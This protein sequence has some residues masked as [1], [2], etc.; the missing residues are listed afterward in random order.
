VTI[1][2][3]DVALVIASYNSGAEIEET[4]ETVQA[5]LDKQPYSHEIIVVN[6]GST[7][8]TPATLE[9]FALRCPE[10]RVLVNGRNMGKGYSVTRGMLSTDARFVFFTDADL[11]YPVE[12]IDAFLGPLRDGTHDLVVGSRVHPGSVFHLHPRY[13]RYVYRRHLMSRTFNWVVRASLGIRVMDTQ[14]GFKG[15]TGEAARAIF[16]RVGIHGFA[17]D[18]EVLL[19]AQ[20]H[21]FR[22]LEVPVTYAYDG[23]VSTVRVLRTAAEAAADLVTI[24]GRDWRGRY[25]AARQGFAQRA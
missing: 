16:S 21:G 4:L 15:F 12:T 19:I 17:F 24:W 3:P 11:A 10:L 22:I 13:F 1:R 2:R 6:D 23:E 8:P 20:R 9:R 18:V 25:R 7:D 14:C 5:H